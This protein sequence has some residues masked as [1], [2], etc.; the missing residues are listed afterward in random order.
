M[1]YWPQHW[2]HCSEQIEWATEIHNSIQNSYYANGFFFLLWFCQKQKHKNEIKYFAH[3]LTNKI[4]WISWAVKATAIYQFH[5]NILFNCLLFDKYAFLDADF[6]LLKGAV[7]DVWKTIG[8]L[9]VTWVES[10]L[11]LSSYHSMIYV[12]IA[13]HTIFFII[14]VC[15]ALRIFLSYRFAFIRIKNVN[16]QGPAL[17]SFC[18]TI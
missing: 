18:Q 14:I 1:C 17:V 9:I 4:E 2:I 15:R 12:C 3:T 10:N 11:F 6:I 5:I 16:E 8:I 7:K 13:A